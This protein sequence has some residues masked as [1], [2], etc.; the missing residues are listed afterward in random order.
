[1][2][3]F[4]VELAF[5]LNANFNK[6]RIN[7]HFDQMKFVILNIKCH[8]RSSVCSCSSNSTNFLI[9]WNDLIGHLPQGRDRGKI[10]VIIVIFWIPKESTCPAHAH[11]SVYASR[12]LQ[13]LMQ[14]VLCGFAYF[15]PL[16][17]SVLFRR[18]WARLCSHVNRQK[19][20]LKKIF[21][22]CEP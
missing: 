11:M 22:F 6:W 15:E 8:L 14:V 18:G 7:T 4:V 12:H 10:V 5:I 20:T 9:K 3:I 1:M 2:T 16:Y 13:M 17:T 19:F 21:I